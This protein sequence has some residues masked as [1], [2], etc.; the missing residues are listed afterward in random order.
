MQ[1]SDEQLRFLH[2][3]ATLSS[4]DFGQVSH[5]LPQLVTVDEQLRTHCTYNHLGARMER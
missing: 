4:L 1:T 3:S 5:S 2:F